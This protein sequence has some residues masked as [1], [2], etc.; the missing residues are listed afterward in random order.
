MVGTTFALATFMSAS[1]EPSGREPQAPIADPIFDNLEF[2]DGPLLEQASPIVRGLAATASERDRAGGTAKYERDALRASGL[3]GASVPSELGGLGATWTQI[4]DLV[5]LLSRVDSSIGHL[6]GFQHLLLATA[7]L[8]GTDEQWRS[9][10]RATASKRW[11]WGNALN[12]LD[13]GTILTATGNHF[14]VH[15]KKSF[16]SG[17]VDADRLLISAVDSVTSK[18]VVAVIPADRRGVRATG[19]WDNIGQRQTDS[20]TVEFDHVVVHP[21]EIL[22]NPGP[23]GNTFATLRPLIAQLILTNIYVGLAEGALIEARKYTLTSR[24]AWPHAPTTHV[25]EDPLILRRYGEF[26]IAIEAARALAN[27]A[28]LA[29]D[30]DYTREGALTSEQR[31]R[32]AVRIATAKVAAAQAALKVTA[33]LFDVAGAR[34]TSTKLNLDRFWRN[35]R[36]HTLH[37]PVEYKLTELGNFTLNHQLPRPT[38]FS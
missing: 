35:A 28:A 8:F 33:E 20:G 17:S 37:D 30:E 23:L 34:A 11:F 16:S 36:T 22:A 9:L 14:E 21:E 19:D 7:R 18:L 32:T 24:R 12:P 31:G 25:H 26:T 10:F 1:R 2:L 4:L 6:F 13:P 38:F 27:R 29:L 15:G 3:L 5:R